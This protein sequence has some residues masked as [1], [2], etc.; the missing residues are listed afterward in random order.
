MR[1]RKSIPEHTRRGDGGVRR[2]VT[3]GGDGLLAFWSCAARVLGVFHHH[4][5]FPGPQRDKSEMQDATGS[6]PGIYMASFLGTGLYLVVAVANPSS[7]SPSHPKSSVQMDPSK[8]K[9]GHEPLYPPCPQTDP[10]KPDSGLAAQSVGGM[11]KWLL[12]NRNG[13]ILFSTQGFA[14]RRAARGRC[15]FVLFWGLEGY[16]IRCDKRG[17]WADK[18]WGAVRGRRGRVGVGVGW[19]RVVAGIGYGGGGRGEARGLVYRAELVGREE[20]S[21]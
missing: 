6:S 3:V 7:L 4:H 12:T 11:F 16:V 14:I 13:G 21:G 15:V 8:I 20:R 19:A 1:P 18:G 10:A 2:V 17:R 5:H 9:N